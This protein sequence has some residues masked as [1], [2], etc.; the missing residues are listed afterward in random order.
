MSLNAVN[1][2]SSSLNH[3]AWH[4]SIEQRED[5]SRLVRTG[6]QANLYRIERSFEMK[7]LPWIKKITKKSDYVFQQDGAPALTAKHGKDSAGLV[8]HHHELL[9]QILLG[10]RVIRFEVLRLQLVNAHWRK[11]IVK[12]ATAA[13]MSSRLL[14]NAHGDRWEKA[15]SEKPARAS[16][17]VQ[18]VLF[19]Q[20][21]ATLHNFMFSSVSI[22][23]CNES[24]LISLYIALL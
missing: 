21:A 2:R 17:F 14:W 22:S 9:V 20:K 13:Q 4:R 6:L 19:P 24:C 10:F 23:L 15:S 1:N 3:D 11:K 7:I 18:S 5:T 16:D 8:G 12:Q